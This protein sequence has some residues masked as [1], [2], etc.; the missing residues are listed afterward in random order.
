MKGLI[1]GLLLI[2]TG[3]WFWVLVGLFLLL[4]WLFTGGLTGLLYWLLVPICVIVIFVLS[5]QI[6]SGLAEPKK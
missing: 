3:L 6:I 1:A 5:C 4:A 2:V